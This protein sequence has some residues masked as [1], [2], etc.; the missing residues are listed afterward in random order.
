MRA[1]LSAEPPV[2]SREPIPQCGKRIRKKAQCPRIAAL[3]KKQQRSI[4]Q[5]SG[6]LDKSRPL[7]YKKNGQL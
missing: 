3:A 5:T 2:F 6:L 7:V 1:A 4:N